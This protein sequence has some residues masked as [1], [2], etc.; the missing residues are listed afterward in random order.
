MFYHWYTRK[1]N[2]KWENWQRRNKKKYSSAFNTSLSVLCAFFFE[3]ISHLIDR[4]FYYNSN[5][6]Q[7]WFFNASTA[8]LST[9]DWKHFALVLMKL[10]NR[11]EIIKK[12]LQEE[13]YS[14][15]ILF[16]FI[17]YLNSVFF[18]SSSS[19][20]SSSASTALVVSIEN[21]L[22]FFF[23]LHFFDILTGKK[24]FFYI[25][26]CCFFFL[27]WKYNFYNKE[28]ILHKRD[29]FLHHVKNFFMTHTFSSK[30]FSRNKFFNVKK[31][32]IHSLRISFLNRFRW[33]DMIHVLKILSL[34]PVK[35]S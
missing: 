21:E 30:N 20:S 24:K 16:S 29:K 13:E 27:V 19:S 2:Q 6:N 34:S 26:F 3:S 9:E 32:S 18:T 12:K 33:D 7:L 15:G 22:D 31:A 8:S 35:K 5:F 28:R 25:F 4:F 1:I 10:F 17:L 23:H 14:F 11:W